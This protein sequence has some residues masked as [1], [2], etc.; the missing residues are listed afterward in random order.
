[1]LP[2]SANGVTGIATTS[3]RAARWVSNGLCQVLIRPCSRC[4]TPVFVVGEGAAHEG[5]DVVVQ[6]R[7]RAVRVV[8]ECEP[9][10]LP[11]LGRLPLPG[12][13]RPTRRRS[14]RA[15]PGRGSRRASG[16]AAGCRRA[17][18]GRGGSPGWRGTCRPCR[19]PSRRGP[20]PPVPRRARPCACM[21]RRSASGS[22]SRRTSYTS[23]AMAASTRRTVAPLYWLMTTSP[24]P[25]SVFSASRTGVFDTPNCAASSVSTSACPASAAR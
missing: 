4:V 2:S 9:Q 13:G 12:R 11:V 10:D 22:R 6:G 23:R 19:S 8:G 20:G 7:G 5:R 16:R 3:A 18:R 25:A 24:V 15:R 17:G 21:E 14:R 1:M